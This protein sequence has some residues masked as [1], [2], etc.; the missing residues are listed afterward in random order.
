MYSPK[1]KSPLERNYGFSAVST[2]NIKKKHITQLSQVVYVRAE[3]PKALSPGH[4]PGYKGS[5][6]GAL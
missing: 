6:Q 2:S 1:C 5:Q 4:R 3:G